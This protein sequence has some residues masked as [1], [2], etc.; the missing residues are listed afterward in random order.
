MRQTSVLEED[1]GADRR[2]SGDSQAGSSSSPGR[3][4]MK[5]KEA[6]EEMTTRKS[7]YL[8]DVKDNKPGGIA[9]CLQP[10]SWLT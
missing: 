1:W 2:F 10:D 7:S 3:T 6:G 8:M 5:I 9:L 4:K